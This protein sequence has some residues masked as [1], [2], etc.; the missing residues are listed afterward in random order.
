MKACVLAGS[1]PIETIT[2]QY[3]EVPLREPAKDEVFATGCGV[4]LQRRE[5]THSGALVCSR[6][7][8]GRFLG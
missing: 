2:L 8:D 4:T 5:L 6:G 3:T 1:A 7:P